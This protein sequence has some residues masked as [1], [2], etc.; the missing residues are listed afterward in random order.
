MFVW[1]ERLFVFLSSQWIKPSALTLQRIYMTTSSGFF[2]LFL[3]SPAPR[4]H[5]PSPVAYRRRPVA[6]TGPGWRAWPPQPC[7]FKGQGVEKEGRTVRGEGI[8]RRD[9]NSAFLSGFRSSHLF[10]FPLFTPGRVRRE[11]ALQRGNFLE[12]LVI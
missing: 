2:S 6:T 7:S 11:P 3:L 10:S 1:G 9:I 8:L 4:P 12:G 5:C